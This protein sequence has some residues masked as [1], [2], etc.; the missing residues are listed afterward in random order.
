MV[1]AKMPARRKGAESQTMESGQTL[2][3]DAK[4]S[5]NVF[6]ALG[7]VFLEVVEQATP[8]A[9]QHQKAAPGRVV[10]FVR[11]EVLRQLADTLTQD[12]DLDFRAAGIADMGAVLVNDGLLLL[13]R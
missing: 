13:S 4:F 2:L 1:W 11:L 3:A 7:V 5:D 6:V 8:L 9:N 10:L 12:G